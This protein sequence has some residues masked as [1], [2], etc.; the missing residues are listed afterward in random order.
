MATKTTGAEW[1]RFYN[2][3]AFWPEGHWHD[4]E[5]LT[6]N[7]EEPPED[8]DLGEVADTAA[9]TILAGSVFNESADSYASLEGHFKKWRK[10]QTVASVVVEIHK[11]KLDELKALVKTIGGKAL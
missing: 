9:M 4:D 5:I 8:F 3:N 1:K 10:L 7:G 6:V 11:G 2:D